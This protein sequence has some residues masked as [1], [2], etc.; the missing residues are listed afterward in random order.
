MQI[1]FSS[2]TERDFILF[3][4]IPRHFIRNNLLLLFKVLVV[5]DATIVATPSPATFAEEAVGKVVLGYYIWVR[6]VTSEGIGTAV[7]W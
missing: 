7:T 4:Y 3:Y 6:L 5:L 2:D 1:S